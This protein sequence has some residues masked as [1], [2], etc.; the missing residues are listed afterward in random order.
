MKDLDMEDY[1]GFSTWRHC[2]DKNPYK[3]KR[4]TEEPNRR[5]EEDRIKWQSIVRPEAKDF[6]KRLKLKKQGQ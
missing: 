1:L 6:R 2:N 3:G 5:Q 4:G